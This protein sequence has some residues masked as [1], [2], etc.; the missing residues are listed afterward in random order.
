MEDTKAE[1]NFDQMLF[2]RVI[3]KNVNEL[4]IVH[5]CVAVT[6]YTHHLSR[7]TTAIVG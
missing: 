3:F 6:C 4:G 7:C 5:G 1:I 2:L